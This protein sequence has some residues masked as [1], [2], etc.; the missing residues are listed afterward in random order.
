M[1]RIPFMQL[2][3]FCVLLVLAGCK[4]ADSAVRDQTE[5]VISAASS[6]AS[7]MDE[8]KTLYESGHPAV[9][10]KMNYGGSGG[11]QRQ[12]EQGAPVHLFLSA[13]EQH[14]QALIDKGL[15]EEIQVLAAG[16]LVAIVH[17]DSGLVLQS[18]EDLTQAAV[19]RLAIGEPDLVPA[20]FYARQSL[21]YH[22]LWDD[23]Q[24]ML[25]YTKDVRQ[26][27][28]YV[29]SGNADA[30]YVYETDAANA[31][32]VRIAYYADSAS[33]PPIIYPAGLVK[34]SGDREEALRFLRFLVE[35]EAQQVFRKHGF[36]IPRMGG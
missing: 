34:G 1:H 8:I 5:I 17:A 13:G 36:H 29:E 16:K 22:S 21:Q 32:K 28:H 24:A 4:P 18:A 31:S 23:V 12:I 19:G 27:L 14:T 11:L 26:A 33:H 3:L 25:I 7:V 15:I 9:R 2:A 20:G 35:E 10:L 6:L 30:A